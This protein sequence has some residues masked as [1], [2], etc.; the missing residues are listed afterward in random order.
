MTGFATQ[1]WDFST[2]LGTCLKAKGGRFFMLLLGSMVAVLVG[3]WV[4]WS[5]RK[6]D[7]ARRALGRAI[8]IATTP[9]ALILCPDQAAPSFTS[10]QERARRAIEE[11]QKVADQVWRSLPH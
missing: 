2:V 7:E 4:T 10:E 5:R 3:G 11:F 6:A 8:A 9:V 1:R